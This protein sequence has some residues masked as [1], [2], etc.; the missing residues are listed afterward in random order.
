MGR[1]NLTR[2]DEIC[3]I[4]PAADAILLDPAGQL[5]KAAWM[6]RVQER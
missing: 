5:D 4:D 2:I 1:T 3:G 6:L